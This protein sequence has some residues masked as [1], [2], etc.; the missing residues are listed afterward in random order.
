L[1]FCLRCS[2]WC[3]DVFS[4]ISSV[5]KIFK[6]LVEGPTLRMSLAIMKRAVILHSGMGR[7]ALLW[8]R[9]LHP[10]LTLDGFIHVLDR[11]LQWSEAGIHSV[12][13]E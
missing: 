9:M 2:S 6:I 10:R 12:N 11:E 5:D 13:S 1:S 7:I 4:K 8:L 3:K